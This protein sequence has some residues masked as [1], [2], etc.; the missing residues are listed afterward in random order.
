MYDY[1]ARMYD[2]Q[3]GRW[4]V[5]D[6]LAD[7]M[8]RWSPYNYAFD[9]PIRFI[10]PDGMKA[11]DANDDNKMVNYIV[12][13]NKKTGEKTTY[14]TGDAKKGAKES[15]VEVQNGGS[16]VQ[17][18]S[19]DEAAFAWGVENEQFAKPGNNEHAGTI[20]SEKDSKGNKTYSYNGSFE[21]ESEIR[22]DYHKNDRPKGSTIEGF[23]HTHPYTN[24]FS[25]HTRADDINIPYDEDDM[26]DN[27]YT[28]YYLVTPNGGLVV[29]R[30]ADPMS[31]GVERG[32]TMPLASGLTTGYYKFNLPK[33]LGP[34]GKPLKHNEVPELVREYLKKVN[35]K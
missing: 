9:N 19:R 27:E 20:Y 24:D 29:S 33:W 11:K 22:S 34:D 12:V 2:P 6:P 3:I 32:E 16:G 10:D 15:Y 21:G 18:R 17:F 13:Q 26:A 7:K 8:R 28:D 4:H 14:I 1:G 31:S 35:K 5:I 30:G 23:I 25:K